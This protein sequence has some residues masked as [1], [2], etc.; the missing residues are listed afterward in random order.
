MGVAHICLVPKDSSPVSSAFIQEL[1]ERAISLG[2]SL[3]LERSPLEIKKEMDVWGPVGDDFMVMQKLKK[4]WDPKGILSPGRF[5][6][7]L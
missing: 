2:G 1:R 4:L 5:V 7:G 6:G 3:I